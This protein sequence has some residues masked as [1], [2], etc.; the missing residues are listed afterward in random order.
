VTKRRSCAPTQGSCRGSSFSA[1]PI[2]PLRKSVRTAIDKNGD[3]NVYVFSVDV[4]T[5]ALKD[6]TPFEKT[7]GRIL[8]LSQKYP[9]LAVLGTNDRDPKHHD[10]YRV[11]IV[12]GQRTLLQR[13]DGFA[14]YVV[15][16]AFAVRYG[17]KQTPDGALDM[18]LADGKGGFKPFQ[19][20]P[21][22]DNLTTGP[23]AF[24]RAGRTLYMRDSRDRDTSS[25]VAL[26]TRTGAP[27][28]VAEDARADVGAIIASPIDGHVQAAAFDYER[29]NWKIVGAMKAKR[30]PVSYVLTPNG[31][32]KRWASG[33]V[34]PCCARLIVSFT[35]LATSAVSPAA[36]ASQPADLAT[37]S[38]VAWPATATAA[39]SSTS[40]PSAE[41]WLISRMPLRCSVA[42][43]HAETSGSSGTDTPPR[44]EAPKSSVNR[45]MRTH[46]DAGGFARPAPRA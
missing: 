9:T 8:G 2:A 41:A 37:G 10:A 5:S 36:I 7:Q 22:E 40:P 35:P 24:D 23:L 45:S 1:T 25:L 39:P 31:T 19:T 20:I 13:N 21:L 42:R 15:D 46:A 17:L 11:D 44:T 16:E 43:Y 32:A 28:L 30:L 3:E 14:G 6:L 18:M 26:D 27:K 33:Y 29:R 4:D 34:S 12:S 38:S